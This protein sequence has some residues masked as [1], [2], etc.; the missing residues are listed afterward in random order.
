MRVA[1]FASLF[2]LA[3]TRGAD[4][5]ASDQYAHLVAFDTAHVRIVS[6]KDTAKLTVEL[7]RTNEQQ[8]MGLMERRSLPSDAGMLF[9]YPTVQPDSSAFWMFRTRIPL[10]IAFVD[11]ADVIRTIRTM[12]PCTSLLAEGC[13]SY[14]AGARF[15]AA[16]EVN[17]GYF[18]AKQIHV[19]DRVLLRDTLARTH[20]SRALDSP[21]IADSLALERT[22]CFGTCPAYRLVLDR[23]GR[24]RFHSRNPGDSTRATDSIAPAAFTSLLSSAQR[25]GFFELPSRI[26]RE[27]AELCPD[28]ATDHPTAIITLY[29]TDSLR[30]VSHYHGC[31]S[32]RG[33][34]APVGRL[35]QL[36]ALEAAIDS[37]TDSRRWVRPGRF[38]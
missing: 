28:Y 7:A 12:T 32:G 10:D 37:V 13:P 27:N 17:A 31:Y 26:D 19:G 20:V 4:A 16:L 18:A 5:S 23:D 33:T 6:R 24:V 21:Q 25:A 3:C 14:P 8:A 36:N 1:V 38:R 35:Q 2:L 34:H 15:V 9:V 30:R 29:W 11:S 22:S